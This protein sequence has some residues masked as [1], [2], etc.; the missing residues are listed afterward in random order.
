M[1]EDKIKE[2][3]IKATNQL[4]ETK[5]EVISN[6][7]E[8]KDMLLGVSDLEEEQAKLE[9]TILIEDCISENDRVA[10]DQQEYEKRYNGLV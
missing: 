8:M 6:Y 3:F 2:I 5:E 7:N 1:T 9:V 4:A 10:L